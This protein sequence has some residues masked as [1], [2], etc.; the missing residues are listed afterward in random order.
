M[1]QF[2]FQV[3]HPKSAYRPVPRRGRHH[4]YAFVL[5]SCKNRI[6]TTIHGQVLHLICSCPILQYVDN[7]FILCRV[8]PMADVLDSFSDMSVLRI[9]FHESTL[10][11]NM[12]MRRSSC[13]KSSTPWLPYVGMG[14]LG[15]TSVYPL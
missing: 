12:L 10:P 11:M 2:G 14:F 4:S 6:T 1:G 7:T 9:N 3:P 5:T 15:L 13:R 8:E